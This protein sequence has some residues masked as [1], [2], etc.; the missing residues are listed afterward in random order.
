MNRELQPALELLGWE[1]K[2]CVASPEEAVIQCAIPGKDACVVV[3]GPFHT[4]FVA[5]CV[6]GLTLMAELLLSS[7]CLVDG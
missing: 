6:L 7:C 2:D 4:A 5:A 1:V 3:E